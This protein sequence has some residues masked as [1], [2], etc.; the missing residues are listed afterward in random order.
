VIP[1]T[2]YAPEAHRHRGLHVN[3][4]LVAVV[5]LA[6][7]VVGLGTWIVVDQNTGGDSA[8]ENATTLIDDMYA[9]ID[10]K[11]AAAAAA[12]FTPG[13]T[14]WAGETIVVGREDIRSVFE[15]L[16]GAG[17]RV[18]R[19]APVTVDGDIATTFAEE[20]FTLG[21][22]LQV[23]QLKDGKISGLWKFE[24]GSTPPFDTAATR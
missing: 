4:W 18:E 17:Y 24:F 10:A 20:A 3:P 5:V 7:V 2:T 16:I 11:D 15:T 19:V 1:V 23:F 13:A 22:A 14:F 12:M 21:P 6:A 9:A 8:T